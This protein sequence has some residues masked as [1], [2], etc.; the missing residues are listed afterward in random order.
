VRGWAERYLNDAVYQDLTRWRPDVLLV[1]RHARDLA[2][3]AIRRVDYVGYFGRDPRIAGVLREYR[4]AG[5]VDQYLLYVRAATTGQPGTPPAAEP[6]RYDVAHRPVLP[7]AE[8]LAADRSF[9]LSAV[10]CLALAAGALVAERRRR[11]TRKSS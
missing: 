2:A 8:A 7:G 5:E 1:L 9:A 4:L 10:L 6:G 11:P 3:N